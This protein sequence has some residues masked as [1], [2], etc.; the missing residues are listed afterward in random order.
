MRERLL[1]TRE[2]SQLLGISEKEVI[3]LA[4]QGEI[5]AYRVGGEFLRFRQ[6][7]ILKIKNKF[8][9]ASSY[10]WR[11]KISDFFYFN[12]FYIISLILIFFLLWIIFKS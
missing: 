9:K 12:D 1:T 2:V 10:N 4:N 6:E 3:D 5:P 11:E 7:E 8:K